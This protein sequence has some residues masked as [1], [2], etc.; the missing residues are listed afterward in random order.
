MTMV[1]LSYSTVDYFFAELAEIRL[2]EYGIEMWR[3]KKKLRAGSDYQEDIE[4]GIADSIA[5]LIA[6]S[7]HSSV[8][9]YVTYEWAYALGKGKSIIPLKIAPCEVHPRLASTQILSFANP[10]ALPW[11]SLA[12]RIRE[13]E[14]QSEPVLPIRVPDEPNVSTDPDAGYAKAILA[15]LNQRGYQMASFERLRRRINESLTDERL[16]AIIGK[17]PTI[18]REARLKGDVVGLAKLVP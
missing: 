13:I 12:E 1:F 17:N 3:D 7:P 18:F 15:Y 14:S 4:Y 16:R 6:L 8:S 9:S 10:D 2:H 5:V 11:S